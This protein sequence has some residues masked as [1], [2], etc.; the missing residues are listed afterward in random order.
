MRIEQHFFSWPWQLTKSIRTNTIN[1]QNVR[2]LPKAPIRRFLIRFLVLRWFSCS[3]ITLNFSINKKLQ[4]TSQ[5]QNTKRYQAL[6]FSDV[7]SLCQNRLKEK[8]A[9]DLCCLFDNSRN[10]KIGYRDVAT[11]LLFYS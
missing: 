6:K 9:Y 7:Q 3:I 4:E 8:M 10:N 11:R 1:F 5:Y 2:V